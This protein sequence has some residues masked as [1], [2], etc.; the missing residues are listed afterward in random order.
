VYRACRDGRR[1]I[2]TFEKVK[3]VLSS[4][5]FEILPLPLSNKAHVRSLNGIMQCSHEGRTDG[6]F[7]IQA[8]RPAPAI[9]SLAP[10]EL[11]HK[12]PVDVQV[13]GSWYPGL[14]SHVEVTADNFSLRVLCSGMSLSTALSLQAPCAAI[15]CNPDQQLPTG[16]LDFIQC[17]NAKSV[18]RSVM[19]QPLGQE[20]GDPWLPWQA[21]SVCLNLLATQASAFRFEASIAR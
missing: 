3:A 8:L 11:V 16:T 15:S 12:A 1:C 2:L 4:S 20:R 10:W 21:P 17:S 18:R 9:S 14:I 7:E 6:A 19:Y 5:D 13:D